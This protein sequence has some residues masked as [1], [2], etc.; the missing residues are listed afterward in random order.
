MWNVKARQQVCIIYTACRVLFPK[1][2]LQ[3]CFTHVGGIKG[4]RH[5][6]VVTFLSVCPKHM[7]AP[8]LMASQLE[9]ANHIDPP[10][11]EKR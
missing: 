10:L 1:P 8:S 11:E 7:Q 2:Y 9:Q 3:G 4:T 6:K 5:Y